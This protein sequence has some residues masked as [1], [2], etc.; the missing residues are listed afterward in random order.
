MEEEL[1]RLPGAVV[2]PQMKVVEVQ[3]RCR[4]KGFVPLQERR[5]AAAGNTAST[6][7]CRLRSLRMQ[8]KDPVVRSAGSTVHR[9]EHSREWLRRQGS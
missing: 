1:G 8:H 5:L 9:L 2:E 6:F 7:L 4:K 3:H